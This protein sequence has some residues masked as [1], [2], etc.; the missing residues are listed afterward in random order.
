MKEDI[1]CMIKNRENHKMMKV[2]CNKFENDSCLFYSFLSSITLHKLENNNENI[3]RRK[4]RG[5]I[6]NHKIP[7]L[8]CAVI[9]IIIQAH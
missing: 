3:Y 2:V 4:T 9:F 6:I 1:E 7:V 5:L 8:G